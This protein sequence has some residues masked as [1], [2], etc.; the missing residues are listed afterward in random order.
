MGSQRVGQIE[1]LNKHFQ[2]PANF[3]SLISTAF[4]LFSCWWVRNEAVKKVKM[5]C[6]GL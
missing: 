3:A 1:Q 6:Y 2:F 4:G 5:N